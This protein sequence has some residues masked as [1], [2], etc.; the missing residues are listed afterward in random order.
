[1]S[2]ISKYRFPSMRFGVGGG[3]TAGCKGDVAADFNRLQWKT[4]WMF[5]GILAVL[6]EL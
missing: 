6:L 2:L 4:G 3:F 5:L 1:M